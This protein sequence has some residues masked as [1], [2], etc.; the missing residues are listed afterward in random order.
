L[1]PAVHLPVDNA[2]VVGLFRVPDQ[3]PD[4]LYYGA[5][6]RIQYR[7]SVE[8]TLKRHCYLSMRAAI[9][10]IYCRW[11]LYRKL[12]GFKGLPLKIFIRDR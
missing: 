12:D 1:L 11:D 8:S 9:A 10:A 5:K 6:P 2:G 4:G 7:Q 3:E